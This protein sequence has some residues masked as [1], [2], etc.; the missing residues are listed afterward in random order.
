MSYSFG[1]PVGPAEELRERLEDAAANAKVDW[2][3]EADRD[4]AAAVDAAERLARS[5]TEGDGSAHVGASISGHANMGRNPPQGWSPD[6]V[7]VSVTRAPTPQPAE[8]ETEATP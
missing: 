6:Q 1:V 4:I 8:A 3:E 5:L 7:Y 2:P